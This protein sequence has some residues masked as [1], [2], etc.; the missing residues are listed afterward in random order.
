MAAKS[1]AMEK[2][3]VQL[4]RSFT[5]A[6]S[7]SLESAI[8]YMNGKFRG[9]PGV[10]FTCRVLSSSVTLAKRKGNLKGE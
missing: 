6:R 5:M 1:K 8:D 3:A 9:N 4:I 2:D 7:Q 10:A